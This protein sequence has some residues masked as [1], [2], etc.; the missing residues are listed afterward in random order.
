MD[1]LVKKYWDEKIKIWSE[2]SYDAQQPKGIINKIFK[3][4]RK[5]IDA[6]LQTAITLLIPNIKNRTVLDIGCGV[7]VLGFSLIQSG[8]SH[9][10]GIDI[11]EV[12][13]QEA[14]KRAKI[15]NLTD[16]MNFLCLDILNID[17]FPI[18]DISVGLGLLDWFNLNDVEKIIAK[19]KDRK[20][21]LTYSEEDNSLAEII[22]RY[23]LV[24][25]LQWKKK[26]VYAYHFKREDM[27]K[28]LDRY[29]FKDIIYVKNR[30]MRFG[31]IFH[32]LM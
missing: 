27:A 21:L 22:H 30:Q 31:V 28:I 6:R 29:G 13:I 18:A 10:T 25:R 3:K 14:Q 26:G 9:Y 5:S 8:C 24:K 15:C 7:G 1:D 12:A 19:L 11:S 32:N 4:L 20:I 16:K 23:Y 2:T 17:T